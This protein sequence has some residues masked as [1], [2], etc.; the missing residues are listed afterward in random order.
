MAP[1]EEFVYSLSFHIERG[2]RKAAYP[3]VLSLLLE[4]RLHKQTIYG[5]IFSRYPLYGQ[6]TDLAPILENFYVSYDTCKAIPQ[7]VFPAILGP[8]I[9]STT[10]QR[11]FYERSFDLETS[12]SDL[13]EGILGFKLQ[14]N[15]D[16]LDQGVRV[17][18]RGAYS[19]VYWTINTCP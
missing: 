19:L 9:A 13:T 16:D 2:N 8:I 17:R 4:S 15:V 14:I 6:A 1:R 12:G 3:S 11:S 7:P 5:R 10:L 18:A